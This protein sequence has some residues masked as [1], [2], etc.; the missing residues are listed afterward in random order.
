[1][2]GPCRHCGHPEIDH[3]EGGRRCLATG[4]GGKARPCE[5]E[6]CEEAERL[7][8]YSPRCGCTA[9]LAPVRRKETA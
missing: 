6:A 9:Y 2:S 4:A 3:E 1:M 7:F 8:G 5:C